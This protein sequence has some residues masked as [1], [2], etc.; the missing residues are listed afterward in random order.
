MKKKVLTIAALIVAALCFT[1]VA[2]AVDPPDDGENG[3]SPDPGFYIQTPPEEAAEGTIWCGINQYNPWLRYYAP[4][5][6]YYIQ[7]R[8]TASCKVKSGGIW[9]P[10]NADA[11]QL[12]VQLYVTPPGGAFQLSDHDTSDVTN[13]S[14]TSARNA[15]ECNGKVRNTVYK[16]FVSA[17]FYDSA[18]PGGYKHEESWSPNYS[19]SCG[20]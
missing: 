18:F 12:T 16:G 20:A 17:Y 4:W 2:W 11:I 1:A 9:L 8:G 5:D 19:R 3:P 13:D 10:Y 14:I 15:H 7:H 6:I